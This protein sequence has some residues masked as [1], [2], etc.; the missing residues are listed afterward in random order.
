MKKSRCRHL[1]LPL[2]W[3]PSASK[4]SRRCAIAVPC[5][6]PRDQLVEQMPYH[7]FVPGIFNFSYRVQVRLSRWPKR[8]NFEVEIIEHTDWIDSILLRKEAR[9]CTHRGSGLGRC[10]IQL[11]VQPDHL[12]YSPAPARVTSPHMLSLPLGKSH[13]HLAACRDMHLH[14]SGKKDLEGIAASER[15]TLEIRPAASTARGVRGPLIHDVISPPGP[16]IKRLYPMD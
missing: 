11:H 1:S 6:L 15:P 8:I 12:T 3:L 14:P 10:D 5:H 4:L 9:G 16:E 13:S 7:E 2:P